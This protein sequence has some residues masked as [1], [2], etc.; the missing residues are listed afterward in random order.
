MFHIETLT[1]RTKTS[2]HSRMSW[3]FDKNDNLEHTLCFSTDQDSAAM[4]DPV[5]FL[6]G[7]SFTK[8]NFFGGTMREKIKLVVLD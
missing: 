1:E 5:N 8:V 7:L 3:L 6:G 2:S 4:I